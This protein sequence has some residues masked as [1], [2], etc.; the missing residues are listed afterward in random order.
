MKKMGPSSNRDRVM[1]KYFPIL[2]LIALTAAPSAVLAQQFYTVP[3]V[4]ERLF[5]QS[6]KVGPEKK[7]LSD[8]QAAVLRKTLRGDVKKDWTVYVAT[9][10]D[11]TDGYAIVDNV[12]GKER[13]ITFVVSLSPAGVVNEVEIVEYRESHG[14]EIKNEAFRRQFVGKTTAD[15]IKADRDIKHVSGATISS[16]NI[17]FGV[18]RALAAWTAFYGK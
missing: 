15:P 2:A 6:E 16:K 10:R 9:T 17:A 11:R 3:E 5:P 8:A 4:L 13:P 7:S 12:F 14:G 18:K 1:K